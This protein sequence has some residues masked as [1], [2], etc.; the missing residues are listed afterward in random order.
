MSVIA[1]IDDDVAIGG[2]LETA[3]REQGYETVRAYSGT[4]ALMLLSHVRVDLALLDLM[5]PGLSGEELLP[6]L[7]GIPVIV[8]SAKARV[9]D[10][11]SLLLSGAADYLTKPFEIRELL[12]RIAVQLRGPTL[13]RRLAWRDI[14]LDGESR[15]V[16]ANGQPVRLTRTEFA[17]LRLLMLHPRQVMT[18]SRLLDGIAADTPDASDSSLKVH[19][20]NLRGKLRAATGRDDIEA[21]W[22]I[23]F[24]LRGDQEQEDYS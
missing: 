19:I 22:G 21:V 13:T 11:V 16:S 17:L 14:V 2:L 23:G 15:E 4:E 1:I 5:L 3:L 7:S 12:A 18:R 9:D 20:S 10:K 6:C 24:R 8:V